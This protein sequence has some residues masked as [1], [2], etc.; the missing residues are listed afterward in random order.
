MRP[1]NR[2]ETP[3]PEGVFAMLLQKAIRDTLGLWLAV[4]IG[5]VSGTI[6]CVCVG[7][8]LILSLLGGVLVLAVYVAWELL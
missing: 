1:E 5:T 3:E 6:L 4:L 7:L 2:A 8:P